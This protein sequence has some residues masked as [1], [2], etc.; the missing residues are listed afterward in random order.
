[1]KNLYFTVDLEDWYH[2][3][4]IPVESW[5]SR[6]KRLEVGIRKILE[7]LASNSHFSTFFVL[8]D[9]AVKHR[10]LIREIAQLGHEI[11]CHG[12]NHQLVYELS[13]EQ[14]EADARTSKSILEDIGETPVKGYRA[15]YFSI[16]E[17]SLWAFEILKK[18]GF[19]YDSSVSP[20]KTW[21]YGIDG[22]PAHPYIEKKTGM[23]E[24]PVSTLTLFSKQLNLGGA[25]FRI[26]PIRNFLN[27]LRSGTDAENAVFYIHPWEY[28]PMHPIMR[29]SWKAMLTHYFN[30]GSTFPKTQKLLSLCESKTMI[31]LANTLKA[32]LSHLPEIDFSKI[33]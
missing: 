14:F 10:Q 22:A 26:L 17:N 32:D 20:V 3:I 31:Q 27:Y 30:L 13:P 23:L 2:G 4:P 18:L 15:P 25:Y 33:R 12:Q 29:F 6:E 19:E 1:M 8:G 11:A 5:S 16:T 7:C 9:A 28:D 21:R 24:I